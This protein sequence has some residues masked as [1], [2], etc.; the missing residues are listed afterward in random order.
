[1]TSS[2]EIPVIDLFAGPGG[3]C[4]GFSSILDEAGAKRFHVKI[5][6]EKDP[7]AHKTLT[8]RSIF[9][10]F[11]KGQAPQ[12]YY[13]YIKGAML[14][15]AFFAHPDIKAA[16]EKASKEARLCELGVT[17]SAD[18]DGWITGALGGE[19]DWVLIGGPPCQAY[20][21]AGRSRMRKGNLEA[22]EQDKRHFL[23]QEY[24]RIIERFEPAVFVMENVKGM[25]NSQH[26][27]KSIFKRILADLSSPRPGLSYEV[28]S[29]VVA[30]DELDSKDYIIEADDH[31]VPQSRHR[32]ILFG[33]RSDV[34]EATTSLRETPKRFVLEKNKKK[35]A[36]ETALQGL[37]FL[38]SKLSQEPDSFAEWCKAVAESPKKLTG[39]R[40]DFR[41][42]V[43]RA[44][45][46]AIE[47][48]QW[49]TSSGQPFTEWKVEF[50]TSMPMELR[51]WYGDA[52]LGGVIQHETRS[53]MRSDL[54]R[55]MFAAC[56]AQAVRERPNL[57]HFPPK[58]LPDHANVG[59]EGKAAPFLD[60]FR[61]Q[62]W[63]QPSTTV[64][65]HIAKD[66]H[67][68]IH[69]DPS[70][71]RS[72]TVRE[73]ARLQTFPDNY[74]FE[75]TRTQQYHQVGNAVPP[76]LA[77]KIAEVV[78]DLMTTARPA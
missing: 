57:N 14:R 53:H 67:Y 75:G 58:L 1:M 31:G 2:K 65:S 32:V 6:I 7:T 66:G 52:R 64:V 44:M 54:H 42:L 9:R 63:G 47:R 37:P 73:A 29:F 49:R 11:P 48:L 38:R 21:L 12:A 35:V 34:V 36:V 16:A 41:P 27:G 23:Y 15:E 17:P 78:L 40:D 60:R 13:D 22:F 18:V 45:H 19:T 62:M 56:Y 10:Q 30:K 71:C 39:W 59:Q 50:D 4:E 76:L 46:E 28:R 3:L 43:E 70:Q 51:D 26:G 25:L 72:F 8:L 55:Y 77:R 5:S 74:Y 69:Y 20:S 33:I 24:L 61:V 68:Y